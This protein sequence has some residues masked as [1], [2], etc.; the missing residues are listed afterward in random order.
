MHKTDADPVILQRILRAVCTIGFLK[1]TAA[2]EWEPTP[3][4]HAANV[5][6]LRDW[7]K[8]HFDQRVVISGQFPEW[9]K[10]RGYKSTGSADDCV[11]SEVLGENA[12]KFYEHHPDFSAVF[13]SAMTI[14]ESFPKSMLPRYPFAEDVGELRTGSDAVTLVDIGGGF[15]QSIRAIRAQYPA[16]KGR[17]ILQ[18]L[19]RTIS[20]IDAVQAKE[21]G[22]LEPMAHD[23][24][25]PQP[26]KGAKY[27]HLR[28]VLHDW[29]DESNIKIL[30]ATRV[31]MKDTSDYSRLL[32]HETVLPDVGCDYAEAMVDLIMMQTCY[33]ME[34]TETQWRELLGK[35]G[36]QIVKSWK[37]DTGN[38]VVIEAAIA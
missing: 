2:K 23:F 35:A 4:S 38:I 26:V 27:Y 28:R 13:D 16:V 10:N 20:Q 15:G 11:L 32:L 30:E 1:Q 37:A 3:L 14:Q 7:L 36:F 33:G 22:I 17:F 9:L 24:F 12:W 34:R 5:P 21:E 6:A 25:T 18:D 19:P 31:A 8:A 29:N